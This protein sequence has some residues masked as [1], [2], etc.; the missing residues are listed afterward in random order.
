MTP[1]VTILLMLLVTLCAALYVAWPL[2]FGRVRAEEYL[3]FGDEEFM[4][5][6]G[7]SRETSAVRRVLEDDDLDPATTRSPHRSASSQS[8]VDLDV[9]QEI[10]AFRRK[11][12]QSG[13]QG[14]PLTCPS[15]GHP[16]KDP[17]AAFCSKCG[18]PVRKVAG[19]NKKAGKSREDR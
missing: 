8:R 9:E 6:N 5:P 14:S 1:T 4:S 11:A 12:R 16:V 2:L 10:E 17:D 3:A 7:D 13:G 15:C 18:A 19:R